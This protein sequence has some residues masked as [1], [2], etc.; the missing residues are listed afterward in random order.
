[1]PTAT[2]PLGDPGPRR[3]ARCAASQAQLRAGEVRVEAQAGQLG[4][5]R[6]VAVGAQLVADA[7][8]APVL[9]DD[10]AARG[11]EGLAVPQHG[12]LALVGDA[13][14]G[15]RVD[16]R[17]AVERLRGSGEGRRPD[18][19]PARARPS[20]S[21][22]K[23]CGNSAY[24][25]AAPAVLAD[26]ERGHAGG[27]GVDGQDAHRVGPAPSPAGSR[28]HVSARNLLAAATP[29]SLPSSREHVMAGA[30]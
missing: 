14:R 17:P 6:L 16:R 22:G 27:A 19:A 15:R 10:R 29:S 26:D 3:A 18:L 13:D 2:R 21:A 1:M 11:A 24:P 23:C 7:G 20:P 25:R 30:Y 12:G 9:P 28:G 4:D 8:G 5:A